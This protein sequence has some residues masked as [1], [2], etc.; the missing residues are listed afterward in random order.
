MDL[1]VPLADKCTRQLSWRSELFSSP[2]SP[3]LEKTLDRV[4]AFTYFSEMKI[5]NRFGCPV[6]RHAR[7][8]T[9]VTLDERPR[10]LL[11]R[12]ELFSHPLSPS[13]AKT[14]DQVSTLTNFS[15][16]K[17]ENSFG[18]PIGRQA[19]TPTFVTFRAIFSPFKPKSSE[20]ARSSFE[21]DQLLGIENWA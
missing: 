14:H 10:Q 5:Q 19:S 17:F 12:S 21:F 13:L 15:E 1:D 16:L 6:C 8:T 9:F 7:T 20:N 3:T 11:W 18:C 4:S 2:L